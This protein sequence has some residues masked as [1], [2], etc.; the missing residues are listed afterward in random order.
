MIY[1]FTCNLLYFTLQ[2]HN[3]IYVLYLYNN[4]IL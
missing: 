1:D 4:G 3:D 2:L